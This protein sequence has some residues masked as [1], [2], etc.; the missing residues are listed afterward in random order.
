MLKKKKKLVEKLFS[1]SQ[2][3]NLGHNPL[4]SKIQPIAAPDTKMEDASNVVGETTMERME[5][6]SQAGVVESV[7]EMLEEKLFTIRCAPVGNMEHITN[8]THTPQIAETSHSP[9][10]RRKFKFKKGAVAPQEQT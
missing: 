5:C 8:T 4:P 6:M 3:D 7:S 9:R 2:M 10:K 1:G